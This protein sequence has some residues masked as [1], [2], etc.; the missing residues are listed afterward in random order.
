MAW[1]FYSGPEM[2]E[3]WVTVRVSFLWFNYAYSIIS[4]FYFVNIIPFASKIFGFLMG[5]SCFLLITTPFMPPCQF[6]PSSFSKY[7]LSACMKENLWHLSSSWVPHC[8]LLLLP[9]NFFAVNSISTFMPFLLNICLMPI[10]YTFIY[11]YIKIQF[12]S[13][14]K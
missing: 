8:P 14:K 4:G 9:L 5:L 7:S 6:M 12:S 10:S 3:H 11:R 2:N 1:V 13:N